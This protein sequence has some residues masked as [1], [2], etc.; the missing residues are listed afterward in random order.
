[1]PRF[2][3][4][5]GQIDDDQVIIS[6]Y[7]SH[8]ITKVLR[9]RVGDMIECVDPSSTVH[10]VRITKLGT[11]VIGVVDGIL[12]VSQESP[13]D[14]T[15]YQ[16]L[17]KGDKMDYVIQK[18]VELGISK[19]VPFSSRYSVVKLEP[20][21]VQ[22]RLVR[23]QRIALEAAKQSGRTR[24][25]EVTQPIS[26]VE[27]VQSVQENCNQDELTILAYEGEKEQSLDR[28]QNETYAISMIVGPE[29]GFAP[30]EVEE[31]T[32]AGVHTITLGQRILRT[33]TAGLVLLSIVGYKWGDLG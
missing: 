4:E 3:L 6:E 25:P 19:I 18:A 17:A 24:L 7:D 11:R 29:G 10:L 8:H 30:E 23:W 32:A 20:K 9:L 1:M 13:L 2:F 22:N 15:L 5:T 26:F 28:L 31:L 14:L 12:E 33:E 27:L 21:Q 16:G